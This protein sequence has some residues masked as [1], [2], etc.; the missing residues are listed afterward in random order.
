[1]ALDVYV[2]LILTAP[3]VINVI[4][5]ILVSIVQLVIVM[6]LTQNLVLMEDQESAV[7]AIRDTVEDPVVHALILISEY[8]AT[9][10]AF[11]VLMVQS[12]AQDM[13]IVHVK[14]DLME[15]FVIHV[16]VDITVLFV[17]LAQLV[18]R[19]GQV[20]VPMA[21]MEQDVN[22]MQDFLVKPAIVVLLVIMVLV[23]RLAF[24]IQ[25]VH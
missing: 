16:K 1:V 2:T 24:V 3:H 15:F 19:M 23:A 8:I 22:A 13:K 17:L 25:L 10:L 4:L 9:I 11:V 20:H 7:F 14:K 18:I 21:L 6:L 12:L 5:L